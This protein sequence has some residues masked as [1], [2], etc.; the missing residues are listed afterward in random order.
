M[1][2]ANKGE[3]ILPSRDTS[4]CIRKNGSSISRKRRR[5]QGGFII[6]LE[7]LLL[8]TILGV[9]V[10]FA[11]SL[12]QERWVNSIDPMGGAQA[13]VYDNLHRKHVHDTVNHAECY[14]NG[15][16]HT[17]SLENF[18]SLMKRNLSGTYVLSRSTWTGTSMNRFSASIIV[19]TKPMN[20]VSKKSCRR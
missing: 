17:N 1:Q 10:Y 16:V 7:L 2:S 5:D 15:Q 4:S 9:V 13:V 8:L 3:G 6:T 20:S 11:L 12:L 14:V 18:W 19:I